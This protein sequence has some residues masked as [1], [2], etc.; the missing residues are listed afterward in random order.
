VVEDQDLTINNL[1]LHS[2]VCS[3][4]RVVS[5]DHDT[6]VRRVVELADGGHGVGLEGAMED[7]ESSEF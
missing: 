6:T 1:D 5:R 4:E 7:E 2:D 3:G